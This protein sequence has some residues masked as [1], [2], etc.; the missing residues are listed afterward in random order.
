MK[1]TF[2]NIL[3]IYV[4]WILKIFYCLLAHIITLY[5]VPIKNFV[6]F[7]KCINNDFL[8]INI[9]KTFFLKKKKS[10]KAFLLINRI[11]RHV[12]ELIS[13]NSPKFHQKNWRRV[14]TALKPNSA[15]RNVRS[16]S[17]PQLFTFVKTSFLCRR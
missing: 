5:V 8:F 2:D 3:F 1:Y 7:P 6:F 9:L 4:F 12:L 16:W 15:S 13:Q 14:V 10:L 17:P 11:Q